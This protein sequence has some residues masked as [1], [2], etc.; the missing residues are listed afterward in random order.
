MHLHLGCPLLGFKLTTHNQPLTLITTE[1]SQ[2]GAHQKVAIYKQFFFRIFWRFRIFSGFFFWRSFVP[3]GIP[4]F[5]A[6]AEFPGGHFPEFSGGSRIGANAAVFKSFPTT[7]SGVAGRGL[8]RGLRVQIPLFECPF[9]NGR[10]FFS[11]ASIWLK[12]FFKPPPH[13]AL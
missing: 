11:F 8:C 9:P 7:G 2:I 13:Q 4:N 5:L 1:L 10:N 12:L 6:V 3:G